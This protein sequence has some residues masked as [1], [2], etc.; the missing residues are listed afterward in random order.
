MRSDTREMKRLVADTTGSRLALRSAQLGLD[1]GPVGIFVGGLY[2]DKRLEFLIAAADRIRIA[3]PDFNL[4]VIGGGSELELLRLLAASRPWIKVMGPKFG[5]EKVELM[6]LGQLF[7]MPGLVGLGVVDAG[8]AG[9]PT[10][11]TAFPYHSPEIAYVEDGVSGVI[12]QDWENPAAYADEAAALLRSPERLAAMRTA[13]MQ[14][15]EGLTIEAMAQRFSDGVL[16]ALAA[17]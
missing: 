7:L 11:T 10:V 13:A 8:A 16:Q 14:M 9:L 2:S 3:I 15:A 5:A 6:M 12:V 4:V 17:D 1:G